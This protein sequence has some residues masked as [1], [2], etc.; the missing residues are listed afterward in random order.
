MTDSAD[1]LFAETSLSGY[2]AATSLADCTNVTYLIPL[3]IMCRN[4]SDRIC[5]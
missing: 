2:H 3:P 1:E 4:G 5:R